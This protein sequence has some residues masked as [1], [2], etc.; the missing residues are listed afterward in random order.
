MLNTTTIFRMVIIPVETGVEAMGTDYGS[1]R[2]E[3]GNSITFRGNDR[4]EVMLLKKTDDILSP[5]STVSI[6]PYRGS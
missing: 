5:I 2:R 6:E 1:K 4:N 3:T